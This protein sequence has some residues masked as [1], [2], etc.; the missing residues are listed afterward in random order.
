MNRITVIS[1]AAGLA[2]TGQGWLLYRMESLTALT[3]ALNPA[4]SSQTG[5]ITTSPGH[6]NTR[7]PLSGNKSALAIEAELLTSLQRIETRL[8]LLE[9]Q[10]ESGMHQNVIAAGSVREPSA[11]ERAVADQR[12]ASMLPN[13]PLSREDIARFHAAMQDLS[14]DERFATATALARAINEGRVQPAPGG[15]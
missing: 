1:V 15:F 7:T 2:L 8:A 10:R 9:R 13:G 4:L 14:A 11:A 12:L 5:A 6:D 3:H